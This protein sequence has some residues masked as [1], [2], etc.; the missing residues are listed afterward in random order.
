MNDERPSTLWQI[1]WRQ[2]RRNRM[3]MLCLAII[4]LYACVAVYTECNY[5]YYRLA[6]Q[7][8]PYKVVH[9]ENRFANP[10]LQ[11]PLGTDALGRDV[12]LQVVQGTR[13]AFEVGILT[14][15]IAIPIAVILGAFAGYFGRKIDDAIVYTYT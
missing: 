7:T 3:A 9:F 8:P 6:Q 4:A 1:A 13:V 15:A 10:S 5:W 12:F 14:S 2:L 11:H